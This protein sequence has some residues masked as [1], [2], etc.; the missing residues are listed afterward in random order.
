MTN[1]EDEIHDLIFGAGP[2]QR[3]TQDSPILPEVWDKYVRKAPRS[4]DV[5]LNPHRRSSPGVLRQELAKRFDAEAESP[6]NSEVR[7]LSLN[8]RFPPMRRARR[9]MVQNESYVVA[10]LWLDELIRVALPLTKW[11]WEYVWREPERKGLQG[12]YDLTVI[13]PIPELAAELAHAVEHPEGAKY[14]P[15]LLWLLRVVGRY[16]WEHLPP[17]GRERIESR[18]KTRETFPSEQDY[19]LTALQFMEGVSLVR[20]S[21]PKQYPLW[22][23]SLN[24]TASVSIWQSV[25][26]VKADAA[27]RVFDTSCKGLRWGIVDSGIDARHAGLQERTRVQKDCQRGRGST[28]Q[29][30]AAALPLPERLQYSRVVATYDFSRLRSML[31]PESSSDSFTDTNECT[32]EVRRQMKKMKQRANELKRSLS[33]G[34]AI[35]WDELEPLL[36]VDHDVKYLVP[37][38]EHGTHVAGILGADWR[39]SDA[40]MPPDEEKDLAGMC[41]DIEFYDLRVLDQEGNG[42]EF[43][44]IAALQFVRHLNAHKDE[45][46]IHGVN[47]SLSIP[48]KVDSFACGRTP[49]CE[50]C[51]RLVGNGVV[52]V[53]AAGNGGY[54][55]KLGASLG[56]APYQDISITDPGNSESVIT[57]GATHRF[58]P[59][60]Y[61]VSYFSSRGPTGDGRLKPDLLAPGEKIKSTVPGEGFGQVKTLDGTSMAAPHVSGAAALLMARHTELIG[62]PVRIKQILCKTATDL[63]RVRDFQGA[64]MLDILRAIHLS[65]ATVTKMKQNLFWASIYNVLAIPIA[66]GTLY[67]SIGLELR[68]EWAALLMALSSLIVATNAVLLKRVEGEL[69]EV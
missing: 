62:Q 40:T 29:Q 63:G 23:V 5:L 25:P 60:T 57:V 59:H 11:W 53:A 4:A 18:Q 13:R 7:T 21:A 68:P 16:A 44:V 10:R 37:A 55:G 45:P 66:A 67:P 43:T 3:F 35:D 9:S 58:K 52:V 38:S 14:S 8:W 2:T 30:T 32:T 48:H 46:V 51:E 54:T 27:K 47:L 17:E 49:V 69:A 20:E 39:L 24:R 26:A 31:D 64:G 6:E 36:R 33:S 12:A 65:K 50:E 28:P 42:S 22:L 15:D 61:G 19:I 1:L 41:P 56:V 34:R